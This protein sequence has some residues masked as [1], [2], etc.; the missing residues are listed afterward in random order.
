MLLKGLL[1]GIVRTCM[2]NVIMFSYLQWRVNLH[3]K[4]KERRAVMNSEDF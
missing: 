1:P 3:E 2:G 4:E